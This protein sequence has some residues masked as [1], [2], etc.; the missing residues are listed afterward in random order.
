M[1]S[2]EEWA[3]KLESGWIGQLERVLDLDPCPAIKLSQ[4]TYGYDSL[5]KVVKARDLENKIEALRWM[6]NNKNMHYPASHSTRNAIAR[7]EAG[8]ELEDK[9]NEST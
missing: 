3:N 6:L 2:A 7:L 4:D 9:E 5:V 1:E 8:G